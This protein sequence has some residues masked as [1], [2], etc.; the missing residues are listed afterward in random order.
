M[1][2]QSCI[3]YDHFDRHVAILTIHE[4]TFHLE[5][6]RLTTVRPFVMADITL[7]DQVELDPNDTKAI[8]RLL[9]TKVHMMLSIILHGWLGRKADG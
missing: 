3:L 2:S 7:K 4:Q 1:R 8:S 9:S 5:K 6:I